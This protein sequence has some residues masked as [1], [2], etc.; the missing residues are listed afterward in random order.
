MKS[1]KYP[2]PRR[3]AGVLCGL[4]GIL[5]L[6]QPVQAET[7][8]LGAL[9]SLSGNWSSLGK[10]S[11]VMMEFARDDL[12]VYLKQHGSN[13]RIELI[14]K[15]TQL[16]PEL[17]VKQYQQLVVQGAVS[18][19]GPQSSAEVAALVEPVTKRKVPIISQ[20]S[21]ASSLSVAGDRIYRMVPNDTHEAEALRALLRL[22]KVKPWFRPGA[23]MPAIVGCMI[24]CKLNSPPRAAP[25][26]RASSTVRMTSRIS[27]PSWPS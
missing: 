24:P 14:I 22:R 26:C 18:A 19:I 5:P 1:P 4:I 17:A 25:C 2:T 10:S 11:Q 9:L 21:T 16:L 8:R 27:R 23:M 3:L 12:N 20:G 6:S 7:I 13:K 15:D